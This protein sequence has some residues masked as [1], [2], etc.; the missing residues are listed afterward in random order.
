MVV[1]ELLVELAAL[2]VEHRLWVR[3]LQQL[4]LTGLAAPLH[5]ESFCTSDQTQKVLLFL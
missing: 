1:C 4:W 5:V 3:E 2:A